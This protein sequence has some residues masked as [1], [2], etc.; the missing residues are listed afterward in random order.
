MDDP[1]ITDALLEFIVFA[2]T[3]SLEVDMPNK[4]SK[5][6][7]HHGNEHNSQKRVLKMWAKVRKYVQQVVMTAHKVCVPSP[8]S[9]GE[10]D[11]GEQQ[12]E[13]TVWGRCSSMRAKFGKQKLLDL[14]VNS[15]AR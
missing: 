6:D 8:A 11:V 2:L 5:C 13:E 10:S 7:D 14:S 12:Q 15:L 3:R 1:V 9:D 4:L